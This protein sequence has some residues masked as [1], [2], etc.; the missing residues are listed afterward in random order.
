MVI[1]KKILINSRKEG[2]EEVGTDNEKAPLLLKDCLSY[3]E[4]KISALVCV[5]GY[6]ECINDGARKNRGVVSQDNVEPNA[7]IIGKGFQ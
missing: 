6:T 3:D 4:M 7:I 1:L 5:S 2:W